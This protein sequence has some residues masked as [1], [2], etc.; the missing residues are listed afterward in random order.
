MTAAAQAD[1]PSQLAVN[2]GTPVR[3][4]ICSAPFRRS[5]D[6]SEIHRA[7]RKVYPAIVG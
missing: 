5:D 3:A 2:G 7:I 4:T 6:E 1:A